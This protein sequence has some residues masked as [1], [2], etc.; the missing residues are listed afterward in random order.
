MVS[1]SIESL[2][3]SEDV[4][5]IDEDIDKEEV[6]QANKSRTHQ[7]LITD[8]N[9]QVIVD[10]TQYLVLFQFNIMIKFG[11]KDCNFYQNVIQESSKGDDT[12]KLDDEVDKFH[13]VV[14]KNQSSVTNFLDVGKG[15]N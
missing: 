1:V 14:I 7:I 6:K 8:Q 2:I 15:L 9:F 10:Y 5:Y 3:E 4:S 11:E 13:E 12:T